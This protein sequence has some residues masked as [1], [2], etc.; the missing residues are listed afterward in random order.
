MTLLHYTLLYSVP[1]TVKLF[2][3][4]GMSFGSLLTF[5]SY[6]KFRNNCLRDALVVRS[7]LDFIVVLLYLTQCGELR[8]L[9]LCRVRHLLHRGLHGGGDGGAR[10]RG[11]HLETVH[12]TALRHRLSSQAQD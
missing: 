3:S 7:W 10:T 1:S 9:R 6:N 12:Y 2:Y 4:L 5:A 8:H 11:G